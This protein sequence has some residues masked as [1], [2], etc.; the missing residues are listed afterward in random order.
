MK[1]VL[2]TVALTFLS[3]VMYAQTSPTPWILDTQGNYSFTSIAASSPTLPASMAIHQ[4]SDMP[5]TLSSNPI[6]DIPLPLASGTAAQTNVRGYNTKG[7]GMRSS[8]TA[9]SSGYTPGQ[10][11]EIVV[12]LNTT[13]RTNV[14]VSYK[15]GTID[16]GTG[17]SADFSLRC[18]YRIGNSGLWL[19]LPGGPIEYAAT[20][21]EDS[22]N[23]GP[24]TLPATVDNKPVVQVRWIYH[25]ISGPFSVSVDRSHRIR[26]DDISITSQPIVTFPALSQACTTTPNFTLNTATPSGGVY[27]GIGVVSGVFKPS[28]AGVGTFT[29]T[30]TYTDGFGISNSANSVISVTN[31][32]PSLTYCNINTKNIS[33]PLWANPITGATQYQF[34]FYK[35]TDNSLATTV[36]VPTRSLNLM[37]VNNVYYGNSYRWTVSVNTGSGFGAESVQ[38]CI[39]NI[40]IPTPTVPCGKIITNLSSPVLSNSYSRIFNYRFTIYD[41][42]TNS[43]VAVKTQTTNYLY[44]NQIPGVVY[45]KTYKYTVE[46]QY[47]NGTSLV[48]TAPSS[49]LCTI[50]I[51]APSISLPCGNTY[52]TTSAYIAVSPISN[53]VNY[54]YSFYNISTNSLVATKTFTNNYFYFNKVAGLAF[55][56]SY[57]WTVEV[58]Y[59]NGTSIVYGPASAAG[60][61]V[62]WG[63]IFSLVS[64]DSEDN[65]RLR[66]AQTESIEETLMDVNV[67]PNP[68]SGEFSIELSENAKVEITDVLG[69]IV[70]SSDFIIGTQNIVI[71]ENEKGLYYVKISSEN[72]QTVKK[73]MINK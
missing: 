17:Q 65:E 70:Y 29:L 11:G 14:K 13:A 67:Y 6:S 30:Y 44:F 37:S 71:P 52:S 16:E 31:N 57:F 60:C 46:A 39:L 43:L 3:V 48:Y 35:T 8:P 41:N 73:M 64:N 72:K 21:I 19:E 12:G 56:Q 59:N 68:N 15:V 32:C 5:A 51:G 27:S 42:N 47:Y 55:N 20:D 25:Y 34:K 24:I 45:G 62:N 2:Q 26:L 33:Y 7:L 54:K 10:L 63:S 53:A 38:N 61:I 23:V 58:A 49:S 36:T 66:I 4:M 9:A 1:T 28:V 50:S 69:R 40:G 22:I 18:Q